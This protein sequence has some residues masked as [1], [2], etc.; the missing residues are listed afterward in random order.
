V[1]TAFDLAVQGRHVLVSAFEFTIAPIMRNTIERR[2][3]VGGQVAVRG[4]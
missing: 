2:N 1:K 3:G 4:T